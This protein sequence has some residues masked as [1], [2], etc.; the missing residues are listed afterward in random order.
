[1]RAPLFV[2]LLAVPLLAQDPAPEEPQ[3]VDL[4][5]VLRESKEFAAKCKARRIEW[6]D[7]EVRAQGEIAYRGGGPCE[8]LVNVA[9]AKAHE[10]IVLLDDGPREEDE[11]RR[12]RESLEGYATLLN[13]AFVAAGFQKGQPFSW[14]EETGESFPPKG[15]TVHIYM[16]WKEDGKP[17]RA[18]MADMLWNYATV[19][20]MQ[21]GSFVYTGSLMIDEG[22]PH[23]KMWFGAEVE[24]LVVAL[25]NTNTAIVDNLAEGS[26]DGSY[27]AIPARVPE[28]GTRVT[29]LF[30]KMVQT[31]VKEFKP[32]EL[33]EEVLAERRRREEEKKKGTEPEKKEEK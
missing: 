26:L 4:A 1:M 25:M 32:L 11:G 22:P 21:R 3:P 15:E 20:V 31:G 5:K 14:N 23:H 7:G 10:T 18:D 6:A 27:E 13:S 2:L 19:D 24:R 17:V 12:P 28:I 9:P 16:E 30:S 8:Y 33:P 29:V